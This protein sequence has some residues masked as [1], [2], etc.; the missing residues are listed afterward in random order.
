MTSAAFL[1]FEFAIFC[2][3][4]CDGFQTQFNQNPQPALGSARELRGTLELTPSAPTPESL[5]E[6]RFPCLTHHQ[7]NNPRNAETSV[8]NCNQYNHLSWG[9]AAC[10]LKVTEWVRGRRE[11]RRP[12]VLW[13][14]SRRDQSLQKNNLIKLDQSPGRGQTQFTEN[15]KDQ[16][17]V[18]LFYI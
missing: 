9:S 7:S 17:S 18:L 2:L 6:R 15:V 13:L 3:G 14:V 12:L 8:L 1:V 16:N 4:A 10:V 5:P 11:K